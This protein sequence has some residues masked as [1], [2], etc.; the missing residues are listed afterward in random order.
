MPPFSSFSGQNGEN[1]A[2]LPAPGL[3]FVKN[4]QNWQKD[5]F[6][7]FSHGIIVFV[8]LTFLVQKGFL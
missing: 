1:S 3:G 5:G 8:F 2:L 7:T 4:C 6:Y